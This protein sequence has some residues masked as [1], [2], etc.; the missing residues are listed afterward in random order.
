M[1]AYSYE[2]GTVDFGDLACKCVSQVTLSVCGSWWESRGWRCCSPC[3]C[4]WYEYGSRD[5]AGRFGLDFSMAVRVVAVPFI[6]YLVRF[7]SSKSCKK[8]RYGPAPSSWFAR[9]IICGASSSPSRT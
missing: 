7:C 2:Y 8:V 4:S 6:L 5:F 1:Y 3:S 9:L